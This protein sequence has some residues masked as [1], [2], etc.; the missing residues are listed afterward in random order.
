MILLKRSALR[1]NIF[2]EIWNTKSRFI[3]ILAIIGISVGFYTG[4]RSASPSMIETAR[5][6]FQNQHLSDIS[7]VST[8]GFDDEDV[9]TLKGLDCVTDVSPGYSADL[10]VSRDS[11]DSV[12]RVYSLPEK[13]DTSSVVINEPVLSDG[14]LPVKEGEC[15][16][17]SYYLSMSGYHIG[18]T[19][20][21]NKKCENKDTT[22][23]IKHTEY[24]IV[25]VVE[26]PMY[27]TFSRGNSTIGN[28]SVLFYMMILPEDFCLERY[29]NMYL[30]TK[31][32]SMGVSDFSDEYDEQAARDLDKVEAESDGCISRFNSTTL[33][34]AKKE[35]ADAQKEYNDK[36]QDT[37][38]K[39]SDGEKKLRDGE[40]KLDTEIA[41]G[42]QKLSDGK[43]ELSTGE[44]ELKKAQEE[45]TK[46]IDE[47]KKKLTD[48][49]T[50]LSRAQAEYNSAKLTYDTKIKQAQS[51]LDAAK[52]E[53]DSEYLI[54]YSSTKPDA[55]QKLSLLK[56]AIDTLNSLIEET[57]YRVDEIL[58]EIEDIPL[59]DS[60]QSRLSEL[61]SKLDSYKDKLDEY[62]KQYDDGKKALSDGEK[63]LSKAKEK[64]DAAQQELDTQSEQGAVELSEAENKLTLAKAELENGKIEYE[65]AMVT[66]ALQ[67]QA[68][69]KKVSDSKAEIQNGEQEVKTQ[70]ENGLKELKLARENL[71]KGKSEAHYA[72]TDAKKKLDDADEKLEALEDAKWYVYDRTNFPGFSGLE[73]D[74]QR[75]DSVSVV[76]PIFF[77]IVAVLV[78]LTTMTRMVEERRTE[79]GTLKALGY[80]RLKISAKYIIYS[81]SASV[82]GSAIGGFAGVMTLPYIIVWTY[83]IMY[84][85][86]PT[87]L[88]VSWENLFVSSGVGIVCTCAVA[89][90]ACMSE[91]RAAPAALMRPK[92]P[93]PGK[94]IILEYITPIWR[95][96]NFTSKVTARNLLRY[97]VRF[98]MTVVG[99]AGCTA[100]VVAGF[101]L[102]DSITVI[103]DRQFGELT[104]YDQ[105][106]AMKESGTANEKAYLMSEFRRDE[107]FS[108]V[109]LGSQVWTD[110]YYND[111]KEKINLR[112]VVGQ[113]KEEFQKMF[114]LRDRVSG[115]TV[116]L[117]DDGAVINE[118]L[119]E[120][121][122]LK[123]GDIMTFT[124]D[125]DK[126]TVKV[127]GIVENYAGN[128]IYM[129]PSLFSSVNKKPV[130][131]NVVF[132]GIKEQYKGDDRQISYDWMKNDDILTVSL[133]SEQVDSIN[134]MLSSLDVIV[135]VIIF[136]AGLLAFVVL[137]NLTNINVAERV[138]EIATI[139][140]LGFYDLE[141]ANYVYRE[142]IVLTL[143]GSVVGLGLG[144]FLSM[145]IIE[146]IQMDMVMF[147]KV[148]TV[149]TY[150]K[151]FVLT[152]VF[153]GLVNLIM[154]FKMKKISMVE[155]LKSVD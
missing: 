123:K 60:V 155:S 154:Y 133:I 9:K 148:V 49:Q 37:E 12:V 150:I 99:V 97:K 115:E 50:A 21:F 13:T 79:I 121:T 136:S 135:Y 91:L 111:Q 36:K 43:K 87:R 77:I 19:I 62:Q 130:D 153:S 112:I 4:L 149:L 104:K 10:L 70:Y 7:V 119:S 72:L 27:L 94:R 105:I 26:S 106:Y 42:R 116:E 38:K 32:S 40:K 31:A 85:L 141:T 28:G 39:L 23:F 144:W 34:D 140:V 71:I 55:E 124:I 110:V 22:D 11:D 114:V 147:P 109:M 126:Y 44:E 33:A 86:P 122:G 66:G 143:V 146:S 5:Q 142:N 127:G 16:I 134:D 83:G 2:R 35:L 25:G 96:M 54:F 56:T 15:V 61:N 65:N 20:V 81:A 30:R 58:A 102:K 145:F 8:V 103:G 95:R 101:G 68:A 125:E 64:L 132:T 69:E 113:D 3:S 131:Y 139:K 52:K 129:T 45:Y 24:K 117:T 73:E 107:R 51:K 93:K 80:S 63:E 74:A 152:F 29:T 14:R 48:S 41:K 82:L 137:Y 120:V 47:A 78:C 75:V 92:A 17:E 118:R 1:K 57:Q 128:I 100:L 89:L 84:T 46:G 76:F 138:R 98:F 67:L 53:Y 59:T 18:D 90:F 88:T 151:S 108:G 6:Y